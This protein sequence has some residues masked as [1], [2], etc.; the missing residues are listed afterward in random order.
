MQALFLQTCDKGL[1]PPR[2]GDRVGWNNSK[3]YNMSL[4]EV[5]INIGLEKLR[6]GA[7]YYRV[8]EIMT[9]Q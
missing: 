2:H 8:I 1:W 5:V 3:M 9:S 7:V 6:V 4:L